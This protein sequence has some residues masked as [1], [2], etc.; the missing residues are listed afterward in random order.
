MAQIVLPGPVNDSNL[1]LWL[2][3]AWPSS[4]TSY[5]QT[6]NTVNY[7]RQ[8]SVSDLPYTS[9]ADGAMTFDRTTAP[10][11]KEGGGIQLDVYTNTALAS[12]NFLY[13]DHTWEVWA[14][15]NDR[16]PGA[17]DAFEGYSGLAN[18]RGY[19]AGF[20]YTATSMLY[21]VWNSTEQA[22][23]PISWTV[24]A[25]GA[26]INQGSWFQIVATRN[27]NTWRGYL[28]GVA[29]GTPTT[30][31]IGRQWPGTSNNLWIGKVG[32]Y[33]PGA[34]QYVYY[35]KCTVAIMRMYNRALSAAEI[36]QNYQAN[37]QRFGL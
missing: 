37:R 30:L 4:Y 9:Y 21:Y 5:S 1:L 34:A 19:H 25:S 7:A 14:R 20:Q 29:T 2:D 35:S 16:N 3:F 23:E 31:D 12:S 28:N 24:G 8:F 27:I 13:N 17:Y 22:F 26:Q 18:F 10:A 32:D 6:V 33:S 36:Q 11:P 15:I